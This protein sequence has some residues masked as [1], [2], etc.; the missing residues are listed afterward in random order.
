[1][2]YPYSRVTI[3]LGFMVSSTASSQGVWVPITKM[4]FSVTFTYSAAY[5]CVNYIHG[6]QLLLLTAAT[7][8]LPFL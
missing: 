1:M 7:N 6:D 2:K 8:E 5:S 4:V 3:F